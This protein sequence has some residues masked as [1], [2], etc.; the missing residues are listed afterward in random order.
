MVAIGT[1]KEALYGNLIFAPCL[2]DLEGKGK[3]G[4][5]HFSKAAKR[6]V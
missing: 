2:K 1:I 6:S 3:L 4:E 5:E